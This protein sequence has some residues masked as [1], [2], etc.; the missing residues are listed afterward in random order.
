MKSVFLKLLKNDYIHAAYE[1]CIG[2]I[3]AYIYPIVMGQQVFTWHSAK[4]ALL[5]AAAL[6]LRK[7]IQLYF[8]NS[9][10][11]FLKPEPIVDQPK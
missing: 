2:A 4:L 11:K 5:A 6:G 7:A 8:T 3:V 9:E 10:G 1:A